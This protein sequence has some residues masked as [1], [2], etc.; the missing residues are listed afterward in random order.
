M[1][2]SSAKYTVHIYLDIQCTRERL[3]VRS[4]FY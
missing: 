4:G 3:C 2:N 1:G